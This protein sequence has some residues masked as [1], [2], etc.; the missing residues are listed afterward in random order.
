MIDDTGKRIGQLRKAKNLSMAEL[1]KNIGVSRS[2]I[3]QV[4]KGEAYPSLQTLSK[5]VEALGVSMS[6]FFQDIPEK[7]VENDVVV[8]SGSRKI[9]FMQD[10]KVKYH[11]LSP[12]IYKDME[13]VI[14]E[15]PPYHEGN[16][17]DYF[18]HEGREHFYVLKG[19]IQITVG[20]NTYILNEDDS[21]CFDAGQIHYFV[22][23][24]DE[25]AKIIVAASEHTP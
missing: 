20:E 10:S 7:E 18:K 17:V 25:V 14:T 24:S 1:A 15:L 6:T 21:G 2:L 3:S 4:E 13:F 5:I 11:I 8:R 22:N 16:P 9:I 12:S 19:R 23:L